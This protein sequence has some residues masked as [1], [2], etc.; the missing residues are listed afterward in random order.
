[1]YLRYTNRVLRAKLPVF[2][3]G[4]TVTK[5][6]PDPNVLD[7][8]KEFDQPSMGTKFDDIPNPFE[9]A[10]DEIKDIQHPTTDGATLKYNEL[11]SKDWAEPVEWSKE[12]SGRQSGILPFGMHDL[13]KVDGQHPKIWKNGPF[14]YTSE[15]DPYGSYDD[16]WDRRNIGD[17]LHEEDDIITSFAPTMYNEEHTGKS[18]FQY[19][20]E[21]AG[22]FATFGL[23]YW[24]FD[25]HKYVR[26]F[27]GI[28]APV[29]SKMFGKSYDGIYDVQLDGVEYAKMILED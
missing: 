6:K 22:V 25:Q 29:M 4:N 9:L 17:P 13:G 2:M 8:Y 12:A 11:L 28:D 15:K 16:P 24:I 7:V 20:K 14:Q 5:Y 18:S 26:G 1:M 23:I 21:L 3:T 27:Y 19:A 10:E